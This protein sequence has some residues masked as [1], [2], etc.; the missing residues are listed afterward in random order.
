MRS[1]QAWPK[2]LDIPWLNYLLVNAPIDFNPGFGWFDYPRDTAPG[3]EQS[4]LLLH[5]LLDAQRERGFPTEETAL[6]GFSQGCFMVWEIGVRYPHRL[7]GCIGVSGWMREPTQLLQHKSPVATQ[8][9]FYTT[10]GLMDNKLPIENSRRQV[11]ELKRAGL[12]VT[13][14][15][16]SKGHQIDP[17]VERP[18][19]RRIIAHMFKLPVGVQV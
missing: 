12:K 6:F 17:I 10:H 14:S 4:Y 8:Q 9:Q 2:E 16:L 1:Y 11:D 3:A 13:W 5:E 18:M 15:E 19:I 7:A